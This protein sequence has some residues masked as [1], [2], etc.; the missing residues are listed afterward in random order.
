MMHFASRLRIQKKLKIGME[1]EDSGRYKKGK[2]LRKASKG[3]VH[4][5]RV[6]SV[7]FP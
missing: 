1:G 6:R 3:K 4:E 5:E 2:E 7:T